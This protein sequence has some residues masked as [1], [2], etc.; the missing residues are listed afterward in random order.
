[1]IL[2]T[3]GT[4]NVGADLVR[5]LL[6]AGEEVRVLSREPRDRAFQTASR[7]CPAT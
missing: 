4:G 7:P 5:E 6:D 1:M 2:I 3:G